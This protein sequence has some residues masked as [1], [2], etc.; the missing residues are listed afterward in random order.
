MTVK[1][2]TKNAARNATTSKQPIGI[3]QRALRSSQLFLT[4]TYDKGY[5]GAAITSPNSGEGKT[6][7]TS[8]Y[9]DARPS[10]CIPPSAAVCLHL[11]QS[12][13]TGAVRQCIRS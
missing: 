4:G 2:N 11:R 5:G 12:S 3:F 13:L 6:F 10:L 7:S 8:G 1:R 9:P